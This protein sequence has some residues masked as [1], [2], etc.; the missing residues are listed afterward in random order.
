MAQTRF[1]DLDTQR[2]PTPCHVVDE[3]A[4][5]DN[6]EIL[7][8]LAKESGAK[9]LAALKAFSMWRFA[10]MVSKFLTGTCASG[11][12]EVRLAHEEY[13]GE[14]HVYSP[15]F[16]RSELEYVLKTADHV[17]FNSIPQWDRFKQLALEAG[18]AR[19]ELRF[20]L[21]INPEHSEAETPLY[22]PCVP[23]SR[24][25]TTIADIEGRSLRGIT[26]LHFHTL[27]EQGVAPLS[28]TLKIVE[29]NLGTC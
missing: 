22:D 6:L 21:R 8:R 10:P 3:V 9:V 20:G 4:L 18:S 26:G 1:H 24:L 5:Q 17:V 19:P 14:I 7:A 25:G 15:A 23:G 27:C 28:R 11:A 29:E 2:L 12:D 16:S 13:G